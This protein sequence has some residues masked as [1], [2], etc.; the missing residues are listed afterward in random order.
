MN[1][2]RLLGGLPAYMYRVLLRSRRVVGRQ[3]C[4]AFGDTSTADIPRIERVFVIN[5]D[6]QPDRWNR[7]IGELA[8][9]LDNSGQPLSERIT[10]VSAVDAR[11][12][13]A[14]SHQGLVDA[15]YTLGAQLF[16][17]PH[18]LAS[19]D[20]LDLDEPI[21]MT[22]QEIAVAR[23]H[24]NVWRLIA[25]GPYAQ[26]LVLEDDVW[27]HPRLP[28]VVERAW[29]ELF[30]REG[31]G[32]TPLDLLYLSYREVRYGAEKVLVSPT[33][34]RPFR[35]L[36]YLSGYV[37]SRDGA[38]KLLRSLPVRGPVDLWLNHQ[39]DRINVFAT[40][41]S[42]IEQRLDHASDNSY[43]V[44][45]VLSRVGILNDDRPG[46]FLGRPP[47]RPVI[48][49]G[50][51]GSGLSSLAMAL[52]M[53]GY[54]CCSD[55]DRLPGG[56]LERLLHAAPGRVFDAYVNV[57]ELHAHVDQLAERYP[58]AQLILTTADDD[59]PVDRDSGFRVPGS[60]LPHVEPWE[61]RTLVLC[62]SDPRIWKRLCEFLRCVPPPSAY[63]YLEDLGQRPLNGGPTGATDELA[64]VRKLQ[65]DEAPWVAPTAG[66][67]RGVPST[68][69]PP[70]DTNHSRVIVDEFQVINRRLWRPREDTFPANLALFRSANIIPNA[71]GPAQLVVRR[72]DLSVRSYSAAALSSAVRFL[73][74]RFEAVL[75]PPR[76]PGIVTGVFLHRD[77]PR[78][79]IDIEFTGKRPRHMLTN[80]Y[81][82][83]GG[84]GA[85][86]DYGFRGTPILVELD[87]DATEGPHRYAI[88]WCPDQIQWFV[89]GRLVHRRVNW[90]PTP[91]PHLPMQFHVNVW[92]S[93]S[94]ELAGSVDDRQL[95]AACR[96]QS[97]RLESALVVGA[98]GDG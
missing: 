15:R 40:V 94:R 83:P 79:E 20:R 8:R 16:V 7:M 43:S 75:H 38:E 71:G 84:D 61:A 97:V 33:V 80:V 64:R 68:T 3:R 56:E 66:S 90:D 21:E 48:A 22:P 87:F 29:T 13:H 18:P 52:S 67:W 73:R 72:E 14:G 45:P 51:P 50:R 78:Q 58:D 9:V 77:S 47:L 27:F 53:L 76:V 92:P 95:P 35:G 32:N 86:F 23:S 81:Y 91:I 42:V 41:R 28:R 19:P 89:D 74:G 11:D 63:P 98:N 24:T 31:G 1:R 96:L 69:A 85:R 46:S 93:R 12:H 88:E 59:E 37:L 44:L 25:E 39:F 34:F 17:D 54:R 4:A 26:A 6:R 60:G 2:F 10:R 57:G 62:H 49:L 36:W 30:A 55:V 5:L 82:N 70:V 65:F